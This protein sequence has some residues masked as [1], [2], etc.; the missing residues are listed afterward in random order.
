MKLSIAKF[1]EGKAKKAVVN[2]SKIEG[3]GTVRGRSIKVKAHRMAL[4]L[5][6]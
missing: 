2:S 5:C 3:Y 6:S 4:K 1:S